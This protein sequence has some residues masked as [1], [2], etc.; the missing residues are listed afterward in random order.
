MWGLT[1][2][3]VLLI[4]IPYSVFTPFPK[5]TNAFVNKSQSITTWSSQFPKVKVMLQQLI[6]AHMSD[7]QVDVTI[8]RLDLFGS[9]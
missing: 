2:G 3:T 4:L 5:S 8:Y 6:W 1:G 7:W 9:R